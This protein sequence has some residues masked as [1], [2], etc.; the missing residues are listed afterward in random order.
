MIKSDNEKMKQQ[1]RNVEESKV[2]L[3]EKT[4]ASIDVL[5]QENDQLREKIALLTQQTEDINN[6]YHGSQNE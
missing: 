4:A 5:K 3:Q 6:K 2:K 1:V